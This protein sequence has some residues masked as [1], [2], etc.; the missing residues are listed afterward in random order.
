MRPEQGS[1]RCER[2]KRDLRG[3]RVSASLPEQRTP[4]AGEAAEDTPHRLAGSTPAASEPDIHTSPSIGSTPAVKPQARRRKLGSPYQDLL[5]VIIEDTEA[6][7]AY[8]DCSFN[9]VVA[10]PAYVRHCGHTA[11]ELIGRNHS[12]LFPNA[13]N[14]KIFERVRDT[15]QP[16]SFKAKPF[17]YVDQ[18][19][20]GVTY[21]DWTLTP[22]KERKSN[23]VKSLVL[24]LVDVTQDVRA[25]VENARLYLSA[26][27][28][29]SRIE[30]LQDVALAATQS[31]DLCG[32]AGAIL[33]ALNKHLHLKAGD[34]HVLDAERELLRLISSFGYP[35]GAVNRWRELPLNR[36]ASL[37]TKAVR[38]RKLMTHEDDVATPA[39]A[40]LLKNAGLQRTR[41]LMSPIDV[42]GRIVGAFSLAF[43]GRRP[44]TR[45]ELDLFHS[46]SHVMGQAIEHARLFDERATAQ[47]EAAS[48]LN[49]SNLLLEATELLTRS[50]DLNQVLESLL[51]ILL[52]VTGKNRAIVNWLDA[53]AKEMTVVAARGPSLPP[54]G[55]RTALDDFSSE[56]QAALETKTATVLDDAGAQV[57]ATG[58][59]HNKKHQIKRWLLAPLRLGDTIVGQIGLDEPGQLTEFTPREIKLVEGV[60]A[61]AAVVIENARLHEQSLAEART[62]EVVS[63]M[64]S[65]VTSELRMEDALRQIA[66]YGRVLLDVPSSL[67]LMRDEKTG[68]FRV[69]ARNGVSYKVAR[70]TL[71]LSEVTSLHLQSQAPVFLEELGKLRGVPFF[72]ANLKEGFSSALIAPIRLGKS[73]ECLLIAQG[74]TRLSPSRQDRMAFALFADQAATAIKNAR[75]YERERRIAKTL[76]DSLLGSTPQVPGLEIGIIYGSAYEA[77]LVG[78]DFYDAFVLD[79]AEAAILVGD[80][81]GKGIQ[82]AALTETIKSSV[83]TL[84]YIDA[85]PAF[86]FNRLNQSLLR[87]LDPETFATAALLVVN[88]W[89]G[90][91]RITGA[92]HP[93]PVLCDKDCHFL[94]IPTGIPLGV[95]AETY[96]EAYLKLERSQ[97]LVLYTDGITEVRRGPEFF[98]E[99]RLL[100]ALRPCHHKNP[101]AIV[102]DLL[103]SATRFSDGKLADDVALLAFRLTPS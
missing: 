34:I 51:D 92:G 86:V 95:G 24:S 20:R 13:E 55:T 73:V 61:Q 80:V 87:Q 43:E 2:G 74:K 44:F 40:R 12:D 17:R 68:T 49:V 76:Q 35:A 41:Y 64:G 30:L 77:E 100:R 82:A 18:P 5:Q 83:R 89:T 46:I 47:L 36:R 27:E 75:A 21:W 25:R 69:V 98:G 45:V 78:G 72:E 1:S 58:R 29:T 3:R 32:T 16:I 26:Q 38:Q 42:G 85:S 39:R 6:Q 101:Q 22:V 10:N 31:A 54:V 67:V 93:R 8:F 60:A 53:G 52:R 14:Q 19:E 62:L 94:R 103:T 9:F 66:G 11:E 102:D 15:G 79:D 99:K 23:K 84:T 65:L 91:V 7:L 88:P 97:S 56:Y 63:Q 59:R 57:S 50:L 90:D 48:E 4:T 71:S 81:S 96:R 37:T 70:K 33:R 28:E